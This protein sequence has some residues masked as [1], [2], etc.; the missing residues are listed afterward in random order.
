MCLPG[1]KDA[2]LQPESKTQV[3]ASKVRALRVRPNPHA[4]WLLYFSYHLLGYLYLIIVYGLK[5]ED[6][7]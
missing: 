4:P 1:S 2:H 7:P 6:A 3:T 5:S